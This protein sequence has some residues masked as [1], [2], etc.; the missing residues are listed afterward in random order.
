MYEIEY[1]EGVS[2]DL[3]GLRARERSQILDR[4]EEQLTREPTRETR[5]K[6]MLVGLKPPWDQEAPVWELRSGT[7]RVFYEVDEEAQRVI[8]R[9]VR[10]KSPH[11]TT[12][13][14]L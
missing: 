2:E 10:H 13:E 11:K 4:M 6:R 8:V 7:Y 14:I 9:A 1:A 5:N 12:E 3:K